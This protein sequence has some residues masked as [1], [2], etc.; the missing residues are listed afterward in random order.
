MM[1]RVV[2]GGGNQLQGRREGV[3]VTTP[4]KKKNPSVYC[5]ENLIRKMIVITEKCLVAR[6]HLVIMRKV[7]VLRRKFSHY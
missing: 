2:I 5:S 1:R 4:K 6:K 3:P 7:H